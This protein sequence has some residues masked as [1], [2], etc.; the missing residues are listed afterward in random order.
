M[1]ELTD[2]RKSY[3]AIQALQGLSLSVARGEIFGLLGPNGAGK[4][5]AMHVLVG[6]LRPDSGRVRVLDGEPT[7]PAVRARIGIAPQSL[8]LYEQLTG[9]ENLAFY[10]RLY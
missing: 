4:S 2:V 6:L 9:R 7:D 3:G 5:T 8:A 10:A 1:I